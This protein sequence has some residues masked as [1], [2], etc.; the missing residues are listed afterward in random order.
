MGYATKVKCVWNCPGELEARSS[1]PAGE[2]PD[3]Y[4]WYHGSIVPSQLPETVVRALAELP[5]TVKLRFAGYETI[6]HEGYVQHLHD[7]AGNLG[8][9]ERLEYLGALPNREDLLQRCGQCHVGLALFTG[10]TRQ[11]MVGASNKPFDYLA[12]GLPLLAPNVVD[13]QDSF[14]LPGFGLACDPESTSSLVEALVWFVN[15]R[16]ETKAMGEAGRQRIL[17][18]WNYEAQFAPIQGML[19]QA[20]QPI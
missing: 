3:F 12:C 1:T 20:N 8:I 5:G 13:W 16:S 6:G 7:L 10:R 4:L 14:I 2:G 15:H 17:H 9:S 11:P 19:A 18:E